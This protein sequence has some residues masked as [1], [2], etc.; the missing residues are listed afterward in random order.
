MKRFNKLLAVLLI[1]G[2]TTQ[3]QIQ[4]IS[5]TTAEQQLFKLNRISPAGSTQAKK[6]SLDGTWQF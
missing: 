2:G 1:L 6:I 3:A 5:Y 4:K